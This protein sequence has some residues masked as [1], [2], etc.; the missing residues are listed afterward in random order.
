VV[1]ATRAPDGSARD[2]HDLCA[3][4]KKGETRERGRRRWSSAGVGKREGG[5]RCYACPA[6]ERGGGV[7]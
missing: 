5:G 6:R 2:D 4:R 3:P 1:D 7:R